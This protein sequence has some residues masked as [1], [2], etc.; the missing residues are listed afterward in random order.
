MNTIQNSRNLFGGSAEFHLKLLAETIDNH[1][2]AYR[3][4]VDTYLQRQRE[5]LRKGPE[6]QAEVQYWTEA[7]DREY[8]RIRTIQ[9]VL[10]AYGE[11]VAEGQP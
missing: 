4:N 3:A 11:S 6:G 8:E 9:S 1:M 10:V 5:A 7:M 2:M